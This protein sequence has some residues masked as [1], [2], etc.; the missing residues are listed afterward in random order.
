MNGPF[1]LPE[2]LQDSLYYPSSHFDGDPVKHLAGNILSFIYVD[3]GVNSDDFANALKGGF[4][5]YTLVGNRSVNER[6]LTPHGWHPTPPLPPD[7]DPSRYR[8]WI[9]NP[10]CSWSLFQRAEDCPGTH[11]PDRFSLL[12]L[13]ADGVAAFQA[14]YAANSTTPRAVAVIQP[15][16][17]FGCNWTDFT[18]PDRIFAR[19]I[20]G[21]PFGKPEILL[22]GGV[23]R[24]SFYRQPC[25]PLYQTHVR[26][27]DRAGGGTI[28]V[29]RR[30]ADEERS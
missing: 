14:L 18:N 5:G 20:L 25:W 16:T 21:N 15:G 3:Y 23:G 27:L 2:L 8:D 29:W 11:G 12:F 17:G 22:Y 1:P 4:R 24:R 9:K 6:E 19:S 28:G 10:F 13:C 7:G 26:F 30:I